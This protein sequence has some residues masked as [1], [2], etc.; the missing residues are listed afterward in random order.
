MGVA[1]M[2]SRNPEHER[3]DDESDGP[4]FFPG[5]DKQPQLLA[6]LHEA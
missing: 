3:E 1:I 5:Q 6:Q 2:L 4:L